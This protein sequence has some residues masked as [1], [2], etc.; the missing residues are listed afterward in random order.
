[1]T[2]NYYDATIILILMHQC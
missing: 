2:V 1:M